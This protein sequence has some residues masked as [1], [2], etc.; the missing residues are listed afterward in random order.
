MLSPN[1]VDEYRFLLIPDNTVTAK[2]KGGVQTDFEDLD[3]SNY[4]EVMDYFGLDY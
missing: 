4:Y 3:T 2:S 1:L